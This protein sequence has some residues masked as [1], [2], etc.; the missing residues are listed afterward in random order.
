MKSFAKYIILV[1]A[2]ATGLSSCKKYL[3]DVS[4]NPN[5]P[6]FASPNALLSYIEIS[7]FTN[8]N[9][10]LNRRSSVFTQHLAGIDGQYVGV[11][12]YVVNEG[13]V[14][15][16]WKSLYASALINCKILLNKYGAQSPHLSGITKV[17]MVMNLG[18]ATDMWGDVPNREAYQAEQRNF[19]PHFD[20]QQ[21]VMN[22]MQIMLSE[23]ISEMRQPA[24]ANLYSPGTYDYMFQGDLQ[25]WIGVAFALKARYANHLSK[26]NPA[27][28][29]TDAIAWLDSAYAQGFTSTA[30]DA[31]C[32]FGVAANENNQWYAFEQQRGYVKMGAF[33]INLM[34]T[35]SDPRLPYFATQD[36]NGNYTGA[37][38]D[39]AN[40]TFDESGLGAFYGNPTSKAPIMTYI[41]A[42]FI[43]A[44]AKL[45][46]GDAGGAALAHN[47]AV[48]ASIMDVTGAPDP[49]YEAAHAAE[50]AGTITL[51]KIMTEKY[52]ALFSQ[53][54]TWTDWRRTGLPALIPNP[55]APIGAIPRR[56]PTSQDERNY[57]P[58]VVSVLN[59]LQP[60]WWDL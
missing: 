16:E 20:P 22:D 54:E 46:A 2:V 35:N 57:N 48:K 60:V 50:T 5:N 31:N 25:K 55:A 24:S 52:V 45:R 30:A 4:Q 29:A 12:N 1:V 47:D 10:N 37:D 6:G 42:K 23:A 11:A 58:N 13:D 17:L 21:T 32:I 15:N 56:L 41:E 44:E 43:E 19:A 33:F 8:Y 51:T 53:A 27:Q 36:G 28:S 40:A 7:T 59:V 3:D 9:G 18:L 14:T 39:P 38:V 49:T 34:N 26:V